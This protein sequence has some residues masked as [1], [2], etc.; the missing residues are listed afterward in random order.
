[1]NRLPVLESAIGKQIENGQN[2]EF[3]QRT[4][5]VYYLRST[6]RPK[7]DNQ[8]IANTLAQLADLLEFTGANAFRLR[9][10][11][12]GARI[13]RDMTESLAKQVDEGADLTKLEGIGKSVSEK[14]KELVETGGL[15][16]LDELFETIPK[17]FWTC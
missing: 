6:G 8:K 16:Q 14:I 7:L 3:W 17:P 4:A 10:Y 1:M 2:N 9:A 12:N 5:A 13:I 15:K 11:R